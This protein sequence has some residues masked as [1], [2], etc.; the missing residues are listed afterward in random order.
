MKHIDIVFDG[1]PSHESGRFVEVEDETGASVK[2]GEWVEREDGY[3]ALRIPLGAVP[4]APQPW[5]RDCRATATIR[6]IETIVCCLRRARVLT[7]GESEL[8][9]I[10][11]NSE[12]L[13][14]LGIICPGHRRNSLT[15]ILQREGWRRRLDGGWDL[16]ERDTEPTPCLRCGGPTE[17]EARE[18]ALMLKAL[19]DLVDHLEIHD[20]DEP[21]TAGTR[22]MSEKIR[23]LLRPAHAAIA[24]AKR[25]A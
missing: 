10:T 3:W 17:A 6:G 20:S 9:K 1:P 16:P 15:R 12:L 19:E 14:T 13:S 25:D 5:V 23:R 7:I 18:R 24:E 21:T 11:P 4:A 8:G 2:F 22:F